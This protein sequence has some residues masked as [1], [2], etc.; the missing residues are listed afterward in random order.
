MLTARIKAERVSDRGILDTGFVSRY[1]ACMKAST[2]CSVTK[3][4]TMSKI[5]EATKI[6]ARAVIPIVKALEKE[7]GK[8]RAHEIVGKAISDA[9]VQRLMP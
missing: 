5:L 6:Q 8:T 7:L 2:T 1:P 3:D 9:Y 4:T